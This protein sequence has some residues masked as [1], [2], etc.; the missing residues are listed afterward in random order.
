MV[1]S[2]VAVVGCGSYD[3]TEID[4]AL[5]KG[6][7]LLGGAGRFVKSGERI[8]LKPNVLCSTDP[9]QCV[10]THPSLFQAAV[11]LFKEA[12]ADILYG[13]SPAGI[14]SSAQAMKRPGYAGIADK[15]GIE[16][17]E[18]D[19]GRNVN[20]PDGLIC[21]VLHIAEG[22]LSADGL[23]SLPKFKTHGLTR[24]TGAV[25]N[26]FGCVPGMKKGQYHALYPDILEF[27]K[28]L[29]DIT[30]FIRPRLYIM[31]AVYGME[32]NGPQSGDPRKIGALLLSTD[33]VALDAT[34]CRMINLNPSFVPTIE[35]GEKA[36][37]GYSG[38]DNIRIIGD[39]LENFI[40]RD[41][42]VNRSAP[43]PMP[44]S[45]I[46]QEIRNNFTQRPVIKKTLC[47][48][49]GR[50]TKVCPT[51]P[52]SVFFKSN[53]KHPPV[54]N[55]NNCIRCFCCQEMCPSKAI[56]IKNPLLSKIIPFGAYIG[57]LASRIH[58]KKTRVRSRN[59]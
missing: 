14:Q 37:L 46:L 21:K 47:T 51:E 1:E 5:R 32:G 17:A 48:R 35:A 53:G 42:K 56:E 40:I 28:L 30:G 39:P 24:F 7:S 29:A 22:V 4:A 13:D 20:Y 52:K 34:A 54:Y 2:I 23:I 11:T 50:C 6:V 31:D 15:S 44:K 19:S 55:Y 27:S 12:G 16:L 36:K 41:F 33:P 10:I 18:F 26:Q 57:L 58:S 43:L 38:L 8:I 59:V 3:R 25:K 9:E 49:C 45:R